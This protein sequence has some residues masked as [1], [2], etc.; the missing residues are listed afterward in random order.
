MFTKRHFEAIA[1]LIKNSDSQTKY[2]I[3]QDLAK[4]FQNDNDRFN[5]SKFFKACGIT[6]KEGTA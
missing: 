3:A 4:L 1:T 6:I 5:G 2:E